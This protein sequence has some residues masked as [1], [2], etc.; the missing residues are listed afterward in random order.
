[1]RNTRFVLR[2]KTGWAFSSSAAAGIGIRDISKEAQRL[3]RPVPLPF[4][5]RLSMMIAGLFASRARR[6]G[7]KRAAAYLFLT[8]D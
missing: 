5:S 2:R 8:S 3:G 7:L 6:E 4:L 1:M